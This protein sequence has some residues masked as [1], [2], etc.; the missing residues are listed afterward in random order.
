MLQLT[1]THVFYG[2]FLC[3]LCTLFCAI[4]GSS[5]FETGW[6]KVSFEQ[7]L[8]IK[9]TEIE[10][11]WLIGTIK[12]TKVYPQ[13]LL[14]PSVLPLLDDWQAAGMASLVF[15]VIS[16][17]LGLLTAFLLFFTFQ[18]STHKNAP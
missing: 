11:V 6:F 5:G 8:S 4:V 17:T 12:Y 9:D 13:H 10:I 18:P 16:W 1:Y 15:A 3:V 2:A 7:S 14:N